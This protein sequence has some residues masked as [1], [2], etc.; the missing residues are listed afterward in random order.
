MA[1]PRAAPGLKPPVAAPVPAFRH[2]F[3][4]VMENLPYPSAMSVPTIARLAHAGA[5]ASEA[6]GAG[7]PSLPNYLALTSGSTDGVSSDCWFCYVNV[8]NIAQEMAG[9]HISFGAYMEGLPSTGS[10]IPYWPFSGYAGKH[11]PFRYY[12]DIRASGTLAARIQPLTALTSLLAGPSD[13]VPRYAFITPNL[14]HD[15]HDCS[16]ATAGAWLSSYVSTIQKSA[17]YKDD[18]VIFILWDEG[19][20]GDTRGLSPS[21]RME[22]KGGGGQILIMALGPQVRAGAVLTTTVGTV[23]VLKTEEEAMGLPL[24]GETADPGIP[25]LRGFFS[26]ARPAP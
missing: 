15:G 14:C 24:L 17:A 26:V 6:F 1:V 22:A 4:I 18:G 19:S 13:R 3:T 12:T 10:L 7:H 8:P 21:G 25:D 11:N 16:P 5:Y 9:H 23:S 2:I 20:G